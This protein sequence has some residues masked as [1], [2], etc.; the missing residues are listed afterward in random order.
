MNSEYLKFLK[1][2]YFNDN[3]VIKIEFIDGYPQKI[4]EEFKTKGLS[5]KQ[6]RTFFDSINKTYNKVILNHK[7]FEDGVIELHMIKSRINDKLSKGN[8]P[9]DFF[10]FFDKNLEQ[11]NDLNSF[12]AFKFHFE[13]ICNY[14]KDNQKNDNKSENRNNF[15]KRY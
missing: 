3:G 11:V 4:A 15:K 7:S 9:E 8:L 14:L 12:E 13:A 6:C 2:G 1:G 5:N 10:L